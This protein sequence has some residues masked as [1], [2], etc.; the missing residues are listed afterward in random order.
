[1]CEGGNGDG[2]PSSSSESRSCIP[3][4]PNGCTKSLLERKRKSVE[5]GYTW[6]IIRCCRSYCINIHKYVVSHLL[7]SAFSCDLRGFTLLP[8]GG[9]S[10]KRGPGLTIYNARGFLL[11]CVPPYKWKC[12]SQSRKKEVVLPHSVEKPRKSPEKSPSKPKFSNTVRPWIFWLLPI[13]FLV[14]VP[15]FP[16]IGEFRFFQFPIPRGNSNFCWGKMGN[17]T[18]TKIVV[19][20]AFYLKFMQFWIEKSLIQQHLLLFTAKIPF[21]LA[22]HN[23]F[24]D[25]LLFW[26]KH[27][28]VTLQSYFIVAVLFT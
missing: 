23:H 8:L 5:K 12:K 1:M 2:T 28:A 9:R 16:R 19:F 7:G 10:K 18:N 3:R 21:S 17:S 26:K 13:Y 4:I 11:R 14:L 20:W 15:N 25:I 24:W 6:R 22:F 27:E